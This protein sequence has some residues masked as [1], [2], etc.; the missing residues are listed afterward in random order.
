MITW[1]QGCQFDF[2]EAKFVIFGF[3]NFGIKA[4]R[5]LATFGQLDFLCR[6][7]RFIVDFGRFLDN[8]FGHRMLNFYWKLCTRIQIFCGC[9]MLLGLQFQV[10]L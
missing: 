3:F 7:D 2:F 8:V 6:F 9:F 1:K 10:T 4:K 5:N